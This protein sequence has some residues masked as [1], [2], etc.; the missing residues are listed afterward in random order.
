MFRESLLPQS[1]LAGIR[2]LWFLSLFLAGC[3][4][5]GCGGG[6]FVPPLVPVKGKIMVDDAPLTSGSVSLI[7]VV[8]PTQQTPPSIGKIGADGTYE[9]FT[10]GNRGA[11][12]GKYKV[13]VTEPTVPAKDGAAATPA[14]HSKYRDQSKTPLEIDVVDKAAAGA[15]DL[16]LSK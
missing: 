2:G 15:Y 4:V 6:E 8:A 1:R 14:F 3:F 5:V 11:P 12:V 13:R 7:P 10:S 16:K 9:V